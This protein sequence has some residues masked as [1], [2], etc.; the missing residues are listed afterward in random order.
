MSYDSPETLKFVFG[1]YSPGM[2]VEEVARHSQRRF[3]RGSTQISLFDPGRNAT[4]HVLTALEAYRTFGL[5]KLVE[6][7]DY[8]TSIILKRRGAIEESLRGRREELGLSLESVARAAH[9]PHDAVTAAETNAYDISIQSLESIA[10]AL[11]LDESRLAFHLTSDADQVLAVRLKT[12]QNQSADTDEVGL[13]AGAV[14]TLAEAVSIV[15]VQ[16][17]LQETLGTYSRLE[18]FEPSRDYGSRENPAWNVGYNLANETRGILG[19]GNDPV[20]SMRSLVEETLGIPVIQ[21]LM[22]ESISGATVAVRTSYGGEFRGIVLNT[23]G[24]NRNVWVRRA[25]IAHE[26][27]HLLHDS[28]D[29]LERVRVDSYDGNQRDPEESFRGSSVDYVEQ[30]ANAFAIAFLAPN[31]AIRERVSIPIRGEDV[32]M[33]MSTY[34]VSR[35]S[36]QFHISN[37]WYK[38]HL[39]PAADDIPRIYPSDEQISAENF[40]TDYFPLENTPI[41]RRGRFAGLVAAG[42]DAGLLSEETAAAYLRCGV[43]EFLRAKDLIRSIYPLENS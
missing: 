11:G 8:G 42:C 15:R 33:V 21:A 31:D 34:G 19:I 25:T 10:F 20:E 39:L 9:L 23:V 35:T 5:E 26:I 41:Q 6:A 30:R 13:S 2:Q 28:E 27:G 17:Q 12:L 38:Q 16:C 1:N 24:Q 14:L 7:V 40:S 43:D 18:E 29:R 3:V 4:G 22:P 32:A 36:A 37:A